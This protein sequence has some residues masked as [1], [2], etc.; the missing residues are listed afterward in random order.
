MGYSMVVVTPMDL[1]WTLLKESA[2]GDWG[3]M[4]WP[5][6]EPHRQYSTEA[7]GNPQPPAG[8]T[9]AYP[10]GESEA[11][12]ILPNILS[13][14]RD[15]RGRLDH[16]DDEE[17]ETAV[18]SNLAHENTH[19]ALHSIGEDYGIA[20]QDE[21]PA[22][23]SGYLVE[24]RNKYEQWKNGKLPKYGNR[25]LIEEFSEGMN[26]EVIAMNLA[27][28]QAKRYAQM[29]DKQNISGFKIHHFDSD[30]KMRGN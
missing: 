1:A 5:K 4:N 29:G 14:F 16:R 6:N 22:E 30:G 11:W 24:I 3:F 27:S 23:L 10:K 8:V 13:F 7:T 2:E 28:K 25:L 9:H 26:P 17:L 15:S 19:Q 21:Y 18:S 20:S 12:T